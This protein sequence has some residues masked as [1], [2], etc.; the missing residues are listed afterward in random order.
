MFFPSRFTCPVSFLILVQ[1]LSV[2][3]ESYSRSAEPSLEDKQKPECLITISTPQDTL[4]HQFSSDSLTLDEITIMSTRLREPLRYQPVDV[5]LVDSLRLS[6]YRSM[7]VSSVLS[8]YSSLFIRDNGPGGA[9]T[10]SQRGFSPGQPRCFG[11]ASP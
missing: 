1:C 8:R 4:I 6:I 7:P 3:V 5:Q 11:K 9:A 2:T 10:L